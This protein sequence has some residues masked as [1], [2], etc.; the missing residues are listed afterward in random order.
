MS[1][2]KIM[3]LLVIAGICA[4][5][6]IR[7]RKIR[8]CWVAAGMCGEVVFLAALGNRQAVMHAVSAMGI[9]FA[10]L[11]PL[12]ILRAVGAGDVKLL[13]MTISYIEWE[14]ISVFLIAVLAAVGM[15]AFV[16]L[17]YYGNIRKRMRYFKSY[18][19]QIFLTK[20]VSQYGIPQEQ[21]E[22]I[23]L[24]VPVFIGILVW[25]LVVYII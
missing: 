10:M 7:E 20:E 21:S 19:Y 9:C 25:Y 14:E 18:V 16:K 2:F 12:Y 15:F 4:V 8:N 22:T 3:Y 13:C 23:R 11:F 5:T 17:L 6:D 24:A 1:F